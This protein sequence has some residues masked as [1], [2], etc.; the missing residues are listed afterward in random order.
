MAKLAHQKRGK[1]RPWRSLYRVA[2]IGQG[3]VEMRQ[4]LRRTGEKLRPADRGDAHR[5]LDEE[6][7]GS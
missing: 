1:P 2:S 4:S 6:Y 5:I 3:D 7:P